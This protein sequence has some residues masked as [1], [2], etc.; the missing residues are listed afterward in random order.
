MDDKPRSKAT[1]RY[2]LRLLDHFGERKLADISQASLKGAYQSILQDGEDANPSTKKRAVRTPLQA[3]LE[4]GAIQGWCDRPAFAPISI[5]QKSKKFLRPE[6][7]SLL[8]QNAAP[9]LQ[10]LIIF[11]IGTGARMS[12]ALDLQWK[13][14]DLWAGRA[15][16]WQKQGRERHIDL[17]PAVKASLQ[18]I[19]WRDGY[20]FRPVRGSIVGER[21]HDSGRQYGGQIKKGWAGA[22]QRAGMPGHV[23]EWVPRGKATVQQQYVPEITPH[24]LRHTWASWHYCV[25]RDLL[26]LQADGDWSDIKTVTVYAKLMPEAYRSQIEAWWLHG[27]TL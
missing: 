21:Y 22:C 1:Q 4:F 26:K 14:V 13:D 25:H 27:P 16:V 10:P 17:P 19:E 11:L 3:V 6:E 24:A 20:V 2:L 12:E 8:V 18:R 5:Q 23:R 15:V 7:A 9:H